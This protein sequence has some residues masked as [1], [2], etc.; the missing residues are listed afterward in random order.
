VEEQGSY[1]EPVLSG[2]HRGSSGFLKEV[3]AGRVPSVV[4]LVSGDIP[5]TGAEGSRLDDPGVETL[6]QWYGR[7][8]LRNASLT[9]GGHAYLWS[10]SWVAPSAQSLTEI[11]IMLGDMPG[12]D[13]SGC[14]PHLVYQSRGTL[15]SSSPGLYLEEYLDSPSYSAEGTTITDLGAELVR[16][17][18]PI[19]GMCY[20]E[21]VPEGELSEID[22]GMAKGAQSGT[23]IGGWGNWSG[24][25]STPGNEL[26]NVVG[27]VAPA[28]G[29]RGLIARN[30]V[31]RQIFD[32]QSYNEAEISRHSA[33]VEGVELSIGNVSQALEETERYMLAYEVD[34]RAYNNFTE[35]RIDLLTEAASV[36]LNRSLS[37]DERTEESLAT[38]TPLVESVRELERTVES[39]SRKIDELERE[40]DELPQK[41]FDAL[42]PGMEEYMLTHQPGGYR[43]LSI[44]DTWDDAFNGV[45]GVF[46][47]IFGFFD[48]I[49]RLLGWVID[50]LLPILCLVGLI[51]LAP[52]AIYRFPLCVARCCCSCCT[53]DRNNPIKYWANSFYPK[54]DELERTKRMCSNA[55]CCLLQPTAA[56]AELDKILR[57]V[58]LREV[59]SKRKKK[60]LKKVKIL[61][62]EEA[63]EEVKPLAMSPRLPARRRAETLIEPPE[64]VDV[65]SRRGQVDKQDPSKERALLAKQM[66]FLGSR[67][68][69][70]SVS[71]KIGER[72]S[73]WERA[74]SPTHSV[75]S[76][77]ALQYEGGDTDTSESGP[78]DWVEE[79]TKSEVAQIVSKYSPYKIIEHS[80]EDLSDYHYS[81]DL[82]DLNYHLPFFTGL[83]S[84]KASAVIS[85]LERVGKRLGD[86]NK[87][88]V[89]LVHGLA[90]PYYFHSI[91]ETFLTPRAYLATF[92]DT[93]AARRAV[94]VHRG[95]E[96]LG[97]LEELLRLD[98][99]SGP[100]PTEE[101]GSR[102]FHDREQAK[103]WH[104]LGEEDDTS[105]L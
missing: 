81:D 79:Q 90:S 25:I 80:F 92:N 20:G 100:V 76:R 98:R 102:W 15:V 85:A 52:M 9:N 51:A 10:E 47:S 53:T 34:L 105:E 83:E 3:A 89:G 45:T 75:V 29:S 36:Y 64:E 4:A 59:N 104:K 70:I 46:E 61:Q 72:P 1:W 28:L 48:F 37:V 32:T 68:L 24:P 54:G 84:I 57:E 86:I 18:Y 7:M 40:L 38:V 71:D 99:L 50:N 23:Y 101:A 22:L 11:G 95:A 93:K 60:E 87:E 2:C 73:T 31:A 14:E 44:G 77:S 26:L 69:D 62:M 6:V 82:L 33:L 74:D 8:R 67:R 63:I 39:N 88:I 16:G 41:I 30:I 12:S 96:F 78:E 49:Y 43:G 56:E 66:S 65:F 27:S 58:E 17:S 97:K 13:V 42:K 5:F 91:T 103:A 55:N 19:T 35:K 94:G 21:L